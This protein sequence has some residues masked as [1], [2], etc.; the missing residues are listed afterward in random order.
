MIRNMRGMFKA[1]QELAIESEQAEY[2]L[3]LD[4]TAGLRS[5]EQEADVQDVT[6][7]NQ[8]TNLASNDNGN[9]W[10]LVMH[11][12]LKRGAVLLHSFCTRV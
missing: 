5:R 6:S 10:G 1:T 7:G 3:S 2:T 8:P 4:R 12:L 11:G 9:G